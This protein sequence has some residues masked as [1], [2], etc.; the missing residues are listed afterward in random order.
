[1]IT[2]HETEAFM[3]YLSQLMIQALTHTCEEG[4]TDT[5]ATKVQKMLGFYVTLLQTF[6]E[7]DYNTVFVLVLRCRC[8]NEVVVLIHLCSH[9]ATPANKMCSFYHVTMQLHQRSS[10][11]IVDLH[12]H[13]T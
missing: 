1:M 3:R 8:L 11:T 13:F 2:S 12:N 4:D 9:A 6:W 5:F 10:K 7:I